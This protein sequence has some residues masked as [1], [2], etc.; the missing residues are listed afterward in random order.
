[1]LLFRGYVIL[2]K[3]MQG[4][5]SAK[6]EDL[7]VGTILERLYAGELTPAENVIKG[8][9]R[10][11]AL[12]RQSVTE[13][14]QFTEKLDKESRQEFDRLMEHYLELTYIEKTQTFSD[15]FRLGAQLMQEVFADSGI[16]IL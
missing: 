5:E 3:R 8:N 2:V 13:M 15:G 10:Y 1:M 6:E 11:E 16:S 12:C 14:E 7:V 4:E 9:K